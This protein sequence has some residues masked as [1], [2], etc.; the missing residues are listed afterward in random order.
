MEASSSCFLNGGGAKHGGP[1]SW[2]VRWQTGVDL[3]CEGSDQ[4]LTGLDLVT[5]VLKKMKIDF[6]CQQ[7]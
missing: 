6:S 7:V 2:E 4:G 1:R 5:V 3:A